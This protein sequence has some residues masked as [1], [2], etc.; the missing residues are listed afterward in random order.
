M[1]FRELDR[2]RPHL[3]ETWKEKTK[4]MARNLCINLVLKTLTN[5]ILT[6]I[7]LDIHTNIYMNCPLYIWHFL[8]SVYFSMN[9][10]VCI[11]CQI[12]ICI[13][14]TKLTVGSLLPTGQNYCKF[15]SS[16]LRRGMVVWCWVECGWWLDWK[17]S[18]LPKNLTWVVL[19][20]WCGTQWDDGEVELWILPE[21]SLRSAQRSN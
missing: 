19:G 1:K 3:I 8:K 7:Y 17:I 5:M 11:L 21:A 10:V 14:Q 9:S 13:C 18:H 12:K 15:K 2:C 16:K 4:L 6:N 20:G